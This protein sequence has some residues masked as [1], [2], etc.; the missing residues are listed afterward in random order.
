[1]NE[2]IRE[3][4]EQ[5]GFHGP[6]MNPVFGTTSETALQNFAELMVQECTLHLAKVWY[7]QGL[8]IRGASL[9]DLITQFNKHFG[10]KS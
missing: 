9:N 1:M 3:L 5:A 6:S 8:D 2:R 4:A 7:D 10:V